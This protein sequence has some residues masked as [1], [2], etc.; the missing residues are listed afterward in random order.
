MSAR[1]FVTHNGD[2]DT[3]LVRIG[4]HLWK[5]HKQNRQD[6]ALISALESVW[7]AKAEFRKPIQASRER[8]RVLAKERLLERH[9]RNRLVM[10]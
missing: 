10:S 4:H 6:K 1:P 9:A 7:K 8:S 3:L 2:W 5:W